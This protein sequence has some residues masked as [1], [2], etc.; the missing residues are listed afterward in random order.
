MN[1]SL[2]QVQYICTAAESGSVVAASRVLRISPSSIMAAIDLAEESLGARIFDRKRASGIQPTPAGERF[3]E[4]GRALLAAETEFHRRIGYLQS[5]ASSLR[6]GCFE[7]FGPLFVLDALERFKGAH[8][9][10][11]VS[12]LEGD[13]TQLVEWLARGQVDLALAYGRLE[14]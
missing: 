1:L 11:E 7:P 3:V 5:E 13:Q 2:R 8:G 14:K 9:Q 10:V 12:L 6:I 4:A